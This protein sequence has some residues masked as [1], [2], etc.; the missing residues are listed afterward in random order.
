[1][2]RE[3]L[4]NELYEEIEELDKYQVMDLMISHFNVDSKKEYQDLINLV[5][6]FKES[7]NK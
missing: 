4:F 5:K 7:V 1:M 6:K 2:R 3:D